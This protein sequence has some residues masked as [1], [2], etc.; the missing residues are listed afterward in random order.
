ML[1]C[2]SNWRIYLY[3]DKYL[4]SK[5]ISCQLASS[6]AQYQLLQLISNHK[7]RFVECVNYPIELIIALLQFCGMYILCNESAD[8]NLIDLYAMS[9]IPHNAQYCNSLPTWAPGVKT[10]S[11]SV[12][13][14]V[15]SPQSLMGVFDVLCF[16]GSY[17]PLATASI[18]WNGAWIGRPTCKGECA[19]LKDGF[20]FVFSFLSFGETLWECGVTLYSGRFAPRKSRKVRL[21]SLFFSFSYPHVAQLAI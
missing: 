7:Q 1:T 4:S 13:G 9:F 19:S 20:I 12:E 18:P 8:R 2:C 3:F 16:P 11:G 5:H 10:S 17:R 6:H 15:V 14:W 21:R